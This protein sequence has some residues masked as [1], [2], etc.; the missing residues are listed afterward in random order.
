MCG[1][2][3]ENYGESREIKGRFAKILRYTKWRWG[4]KTYLGVETAHDALAKEIDQRARVCARN[5]RGPDNPK[6]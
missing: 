1:S 4:R 5:V 3:G 6:K 2:D